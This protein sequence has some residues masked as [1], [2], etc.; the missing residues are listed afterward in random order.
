MGETLQ[1]AV[2]LV[3]PVLTIGAAW[4]GIK[5]GLNGT[6]ESVRRIEN[7]VTKIDGQVDQN[8]VDIATLKGQLGA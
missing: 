2:A 1:L 4:G 5:V 3:T 6:K 7:T 8:R